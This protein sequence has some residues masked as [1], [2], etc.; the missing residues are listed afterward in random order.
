MSDGETADSGKITML[1]IATNVPLH[2]GHLSADVSGTIRKS[3]VRMVIVGEDSDGTL[4][5]EDDNPFNFGP[6]GNHSG[7]MNAFLFVAQLANAIRVDG[8]CIY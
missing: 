1:V 6:N 4:D 7:L 8:R 5:P 2:I 3:I